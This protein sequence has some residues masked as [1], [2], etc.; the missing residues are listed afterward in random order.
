MSMFMSP[1]RRLWSFGL[2]SLLGPGS[3]REKQFSQSE[4]TVLIIDQ[5][6]ICRPF[7]FYYY[8]LISP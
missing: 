6:N 3:S 4:F 7:F 5:H 2:L 8:F 1:I